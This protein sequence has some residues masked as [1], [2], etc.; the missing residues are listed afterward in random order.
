MSS[1]KVVP[2]WLWAVGIGA[3][4]SLAVAAVLAQLVYRA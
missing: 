4:V 3:T 1:L 2:G